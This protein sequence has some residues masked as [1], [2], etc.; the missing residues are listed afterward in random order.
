[1]VLGNA[2]GWR[3]YDGLVNVGFNRHYRVQHGADGFV[4]GAAPSTGIKPN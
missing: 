1:M 3:G 2:D 4:R